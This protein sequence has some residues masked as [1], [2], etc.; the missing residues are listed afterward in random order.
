MR[1]YDV[2]GLGNAI[3]DIFLELDDAEFASLDF[4]RGTM[5]LVEADDQHQLL[6][7]FSEGK[8][9]LRLV[10]WRFGRKLS[11]WTIAIGWPSF[12]YRLCG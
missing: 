1:D 7:Q 9:E 4:E 6:H 10:K 11:H 12:L 5:R 3:V 2:C 8:R